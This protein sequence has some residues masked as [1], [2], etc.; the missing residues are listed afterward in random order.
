MDASGDPINATVAMTFRL[1]NVASGGT[2]LWIESWPSVIATDGLFN[3]LLGNATPHPQT[4]FTENSNLWLGIQFGTDGEM[5]PRVEVGRVPYAAQALAVPDGA[6]TPSML[7]DEAVSSEKTALQHYSVE[8][9]FFQTSSTTFVDIPGSAITFTVNSTSTAL[10]G[11][12]GSIY[13]MMQIDG[14]AGVF[15]TVNVDGND[16]TDL[17]NQDFFAWSGSYCAPNAAI[18]PAGFTTLLTVGHGTHVL[19]LRILSSSYNP[20]YRYAGIG[21]NERSTTFSV[22]IL[23]K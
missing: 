14:A 9:D 7:A 23:G 17:V 13:T 11:F 1:Y 5:S 15:M 3:A 20:E 18:S 4:M 16:R 21:Y 22:V 2:A 8:L 19:K 6:I 12:A 10:L